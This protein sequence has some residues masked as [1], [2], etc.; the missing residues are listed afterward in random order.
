MSK[1]TQENGVI[2]YRGPSLLDGAP[3]ICIATGLKHKSRNDKTGAMVQTFI[4]R[5]DVSPLAAIASGADASICGDCPARG[6]L[7]LGL[8]RFC[9]VDVGKS[10]SGVWKARDGYR[11]DWSEE[12]FR[13]RKVRLGAYGDPA[14]VPYWVW[15]RVLRLAAG[16]TGYTHQWRRFPELAQ[17]V[18]ASADS[19][20]DRLQARMLGFRTFRTRL[21][22]EPRL[23]RE[24]ICPASAEAGHKTNCFACGACGGLQARARADIV[25]VAHGPAPKVNAYAA[26]RAA[27]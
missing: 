24:V 11:V 2:L 12:T 14:A 9:Y 3:I 1:W 15:E 27:I 21:D 17:F 4:L 5:D 10:V 13:G 25:I 20:A 18:M 6:N 26:Y 16:H 7:G 19:E 8:P 23:E 22:T